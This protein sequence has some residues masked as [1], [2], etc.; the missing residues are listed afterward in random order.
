MALFQPENIR[1]KR[2]AAESDRK[3]HGSIGVLRGSALDSGE[4]ELELLA[5]CGNRGTTC[6][7]PAEATAGLIRSGYRKTVKLNKGGYFI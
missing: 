2:T 3:D 4:P 7:H 1:T 5:N 6:C